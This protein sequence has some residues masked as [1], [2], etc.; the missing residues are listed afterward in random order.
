MLW[1]TCSPVATSFC[2]NPMT[3]SEWWTQFQTP[4]EPSVLAGFL[5]N[6]K[7]Y[8]HPTQRNPCLCV[9]QGDFG[10]LENQLEANVCRMSPSLKAGIWHQSGEQWCSPEEVP[11]SRAGAAFSAWEGSQSLH[12]SLIHVPLLF[13]LFQ[14]QSAIVVWGSSDISLTFL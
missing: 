9:T 10:R 2:L 12:P 11:P 8:C 14:T 3:Q 7:L 5:F 6:P 1:N 13:I 4:P